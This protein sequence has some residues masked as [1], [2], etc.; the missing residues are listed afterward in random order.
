MTDRFE[1]ALGRRLTECKGAILTIKAFKFVTSNFDG[2]YR[3]GLFI[4][5]F[6]FLCGM[7]EPVIGQPIDLDEDSGVREWLERSVNALKVRKVNSTAGTPNREK[8]EVKGRLP[9]ITPG[10]IPSSLPH[11]EWQD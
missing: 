9:S 7:G 3:L 5:D 10:E 6:K 11:I 2:T 4:Q 8:E 1:E